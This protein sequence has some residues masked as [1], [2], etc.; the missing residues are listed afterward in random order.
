MFE[1]CVVGDVVVM[2]V[3]F[4][5][6]FF[7]LVLFIGWCVVFGVGEVVGMMLCDIV[8]CVLCLLGIC[9]FFLFGVGL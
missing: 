9:F 5:M 8:M 4:V 6:R 1:C 2:C 3:V 7:W